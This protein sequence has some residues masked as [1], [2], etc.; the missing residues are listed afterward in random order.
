MFYNLKILFFTILYFMSLIL[1]YFV[2]K[3]YSLPVNFD[4]PFVF[5]LLI[6]GAIIL[7]SSIIVLLIHFVLKKIINLF[8]NLLKKQQINNN[9]FLVWLNFTIVSY[10]LVF[11]AFMFLIRY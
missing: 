3:Q 2:D 1:V 5:A 11:I 6:W 7:I 8:L 4:N 10:I 9:G